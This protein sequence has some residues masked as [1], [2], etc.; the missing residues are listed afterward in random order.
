MEL[1]C[2]AAAATPEIQVD[3]DEIL[4]LAADWDDAGRSHSELEHI[5]E[6]ILVSFDGDSDMRSFG[7][8]LC[9]TILEHDDLPAFQLGNIQTC[10]AILDDTS[11]ESG[12]WLAAASSNLWRAARLATQAGVRGVEIQEWQQRVK[13]LQEGWVDLPDEEMQA[14]DVPA[15]TKGKYAN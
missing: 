2:S 14:E 12:D 10:A 4:A 6:V 7:L 8:E 9:E 5:I 3:S 13:E 11:G 1:E 15:A